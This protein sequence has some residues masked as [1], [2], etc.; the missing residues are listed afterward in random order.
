[1]LCDRC[2]KN[3]ALN[4]Y[5]QNI[6]GKIYECHLC[7][8]CTKNLTHVNIFIDELLG[9]L[10][11][12]HNSVLTESVQKK[13]LKCNNAINDIVKIGK[14]GCSDCYIQFKDM[15][16]PSIKK[17]HVSTKHMGNVPLSFHSEKSPKISILKAK[18]DA[19]IKKQEFELAA[20]IRDQINNLKRE[21]DE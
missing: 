8:E 12:A 20:E 17:L 19:A 1:M 9:G 7:H 11:G 6:N 18:L 15:L 21:G 16:M 13:C 10:I 2:K 14:V 5:K 3:L 4:Y